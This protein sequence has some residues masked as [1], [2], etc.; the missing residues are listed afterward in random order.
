MREVLVEGVPSYMKPALLEF[1]K[2]HLARS[3]SSTGSWFFQTQTLMR[4]DLVARR[5]PSYIDRLDQ[6]TWPGFFL[7][8]GDDELLDLADWVIHQNNRSI[9]NNLEQLLE[10][11]GSVWTVGRRNGQSGLIRRMPESI[12]IAVE[13][14]LREGSAGSLLGEAWAAAYGR[15]PDP[16][17]SY[18]KA[19]K[20]VEEVAANIVSPKNVR[21]TLGTMIRDM[22]AQQDWTVEL[23]GNEAGALVVMAEALWTGQESRHG[24][25]GYRH[26][27]QLEAETA[28]TL[29]VAL[30]QLFASGAV[31]RRSMSS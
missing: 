7:R 17:E 30:V 31:G 20:A 15:S 25:N 21:A 27:T 14:T 2:P 23:P 29:A 18:E 24:G 19:I 12:Q 4:Y 1:L 3:S 13:A 5:Q 22:K 11:A 6:S 10:A 28:V 26:P 16:E 9:A 8:L